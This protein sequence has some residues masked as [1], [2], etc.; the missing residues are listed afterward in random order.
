MVYRFCV[1]LFV[2][3]FFSLANAVEVTKDV[4]AEDVSELVN[5][6]KESGA[7]IVKEDKKLLAGLKNYGVDFINN[8]SGKT[9]RSKIVP[10]EN[11]VL[12]VGDQLDVK[13]YGFDDLE[14]KF[15]I[16][17]D[18]TISIPKFG[19][20]KIVGSTF[21]DAKKILA[22]SFKQGYPNSDT[23]TS[24]EVISDIEIY[25]SGMVNNP[26][27]HLVPGFSTV[28][29]SLRISGG[30]NEGAS[31]RNVSITRNGKKLIYD[32]YEY[33]GGDKDFSSLL[34]KDGDFISVENANSLVG[35]DG[36]VKR[37]AI[38]ELKDGQTF[39][40]LLELGKGLDSKANT[41][42]II[43]KR[44][45]KRKGVVFSYID[46]NKHLEMKLQDGDYINISFLGKNEQDF[47]TIDGAV[48]SPSTYLFDNKMT[49]E[50]LLAKA[51]GVT[52]TADKENILITRTKIVDGY[53]VLKHIR[54]DSLNFV[55]E[56]FDQVFVN[57]FKNWDSLNSVEIKGAVKI[58]GRYLLNKDSSLKDLIYIAGGFDEGADFYGVSI[59]REDLKK[60]QEELKQ[61]RIDDLK[62]KLSSSIY[63]SIYENKDPE[64]VR[65]KIMNIE[66]EIAQLEN[67][68]IQKNGESGK[69]SLSLGEY[70]ADNLEIK[71][72]DGDIVNI[73]FKEFYIYVEGEVLKPSTLPYSENLTAKDYIERCAG[74]TKRADIESSYILKRSG[75]A[76]RLNMTSSKV[77]RPGDVIV[78]G[79]KD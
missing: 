70:G 53:R 60:R 3:V 45:D 26:S 49:L 30:I 76:E 55:L 42:N 46:I 43:L 77:L 33:I 56:P 68:M 64:T 62:A 4:K 25:T 75:E 19:P 51:E 59:F 38:Y 47:V 15:T 39:K 13:V 9:I 37:P 5:D 23:M 67:S 52:N 12:R 2:M 18:G 24:I 71:L 8:S 58:P 35:I 20:I 28:I 7:K 1:M 72:L 50:E 36:A 17:N 31:I 65:I 57:K 79:G 69:I 34:L 14:L 44:V 41:R 32:L 78:I 63:G 29:D 73:P 11:Y 10:P 6:I 27:V 48:Y 22:K 16:K 21:S 66:K 40:D 54:A 61:K 74:F